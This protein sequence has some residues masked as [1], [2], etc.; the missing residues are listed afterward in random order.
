MSKRLETLLVA[1]LVS[2]ALLLSLSSMRTINETADE[3]PHIAAAYSYLHKAD[4]RLNVE[5]PPLSK[6]IAALPLLALNPRFDDR[7]ISWNFSRAWEVGRKFLYEWNTPER[8]VFWARVPMVGLYASLALLLWLAARRLYGQESGLLALLLAL[9]TPDLL[10]HGQL[11]TNDL[12]ISFFFFAAV[13][14]FYRALVKGGAW[15]TLLMASA[16]GG[17]ASAK[18]TA[19]LLGL[20]LVALAILYVAFAGRCTDLGAPPPLPAR[21]AR[22]VLLGLAAL[23]GTAL[24][25]WA[26]YGFR[27]AISPDLEILVPWEEFDA[28]S[29]ITQLVL[30]L[31]Q[32][33]L[34]PEAYLAGILESFRMLS[35]RQ[36]FLFGELYSGGR[37]Y[38]FLVTFL[39]KTPIPLLVLLL[40]AFRWKRGAVSFS[41][42]CL[43]LP[44]AL[45]LLV[46]MQSE[47]NI[48]NRH[49]L[50]IYPFLIVWSAQCGRIFAQGQAVPPG[51]EGKR[52]P[53]LLPVQWQRLG[54][55]LLLL[56]LLVG[57]VRIYPNYLSYFNEFAGG[58][59]GGA[60]YLADSN[61]DW[62]QN[63]KGLADYQRTHP[64]QKL[65]LCYFGTA[66]PAYYLPG[67]VALP[68]MT[69][70]SGP[71]VVPPSGATVAI[72]QNLLTGIHLRTTPEIRNF[73]Q[74]LKQESPIDRIGYSIF[75]YRQP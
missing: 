54:L 57:V 72:S 25:V 32:W 15:N 14:F 50:P 36:S 63:L 38:Y 16:C 48:G 29:W 27:Y 41:S 8:I 30:H 2:V 62:G 55:G 56:W 45:Y 4:F 17:A 28:R 49:I 39:L 66:E 42:W 44:P 26:V 1:A 71:F 31:R 18:L 9:F 64:E 58:P 3:V 40:A 53:S 11:V 21:L 10:A 68:C 69:Y 19:P 20:A 37:W 74:T 47:V 33:R 24:I 6:E 35:E 23:A 43:L 73:I 70:N 12:T 22:V 13:W 46:A 51:P 61:I 5:H 60:R 52:Y 34:L 67:A 59:G 65:Y 75:I 7:D